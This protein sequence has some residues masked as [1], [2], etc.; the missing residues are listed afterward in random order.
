M[1]KLNMFNFVTLNGFYKGP[2]EDTSW[3]NHGGEESEY[4]AE[5]LKAENILLFGRRT[6]EMMASFWPSPMAHEM[7]T[8]VAVRMNQS[9]KIV[10]SSTMKKAEWNNTRVIKNNLVNEV[11][12]LKQ[13]KGKDM[14]ILGSG[15][16]VTQL[17]EAGL[18]DSYQIMIDPIAIGDGTPIFKNIK[19]PLSLKLEDSRVFK[20]G[21]L[22]LS[23]QP[24]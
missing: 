2:G 9:E 20:S 12:Q 14:T 3:H 10:F 13:A 5:A 4:S 18:I 21:I 24:V 22:L 19:T 11:T 17:A 16:I 23:Y 6:Y 7:F 8:E 15:S 1:R